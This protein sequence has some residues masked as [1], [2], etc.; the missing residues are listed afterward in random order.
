MTS[1]S[2]LLRSLSLT[3]TSSKM[4]EFVKHELNASSHLPIYLLVTF[5]N[6]I[7]SLL[8]TIYLFSLFF[9]GKEQSRLIRKKFYKYF[10][11]S[12]LI[13]TLANLMAI[14]RIL[15][16]SQTR[17]SHTFFIV[18]LGLVI[19]LQICSVFTLQYSILEIFCVLEPVL[20]KLLPFYLR[21]SICF[22]ILQILSLALPLVMYGCGFAILSDGSTN[23]IYLVITACVFV[24]YSLWAI[25]SSLYLFYILYHTLDKY[26]KENRGTDTTLS[27]TL[28]RLLIAV[29]SIYWLTLFL[30]LTALTAPELIAEIAAA[31]CFLLSVIPAFL[32]YI[33]T[34]SATIALVK[35]NS[36]PGLED[37]QSKPLPPT[38]LLKDVPG[39]AS[40]HNKPQS[41]RLQDSRV[42]RD[43]VALMD[44]NEKVNA[45]EMTPGPAKQGQ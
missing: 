39:E 5:F 43:Q 25:S 1:T 12:L 32:L 31:E 38:V 33:Y 17:N 16:N 34:C 44:S 37:I 23:G 6:A 2:L 42:K 45:N 19:S 13:N 18:S 11:V 35:T 14:L 40:L 28:K 20:E 3:I 27:I 36:V 41:L 30:A 24:L 9:G 29:S 8:S 22:A 4:F 7:A 10:T 21:G 15:P 26:Y